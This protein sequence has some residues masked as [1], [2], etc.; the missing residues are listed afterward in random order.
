CHR[1]S[2]CPVLVEAAEEDGGEAW[3]VDL[4]VELVIA[5]EAGERPVAAPEEHGAPIE[6]AEIGVEELVGT[7][8]EESGDGHGRLERDHRTRVLRLSRLQQ[9]PDPYAAPGRRSERLQDQ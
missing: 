6:D 1:L 4:Q 5:G 7:V 9:D 2:G 8:A 3:V